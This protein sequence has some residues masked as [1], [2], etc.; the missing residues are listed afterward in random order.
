MKNIIV[1]LSLIIG[2]VACKKET[3]DNGS[4]VTCYINGVK[5]SLEGGN[6]YTNIVILPQ[7][8]G[9]KLVEINFA[10]NSN[11]RLNYNFFYTTYSTP[12]DTLSINKT[13]PTG[14]EFGSLNSYHN[15]YNNIDGNS[16]NLQ[17]KLTRISN[18]TIDGTFS[19]KIIGIN[20]K[21]GETVSD[22]ISNGVFIN[23]PYT[24]N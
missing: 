20:T 6:V 11:I 1:I 19:G 14:N 17:T 22:S 10:S 13:Y 16:F 23:V 9:N 5:T 24:F 4:S 7:N 12:N 2:F 3:P 8:S 21:T 18:G 15:I